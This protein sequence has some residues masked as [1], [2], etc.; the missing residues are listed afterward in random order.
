MTEER[1]RQR[2]QTEKTDRE[3]PRFVTEKAG[4]NRNCLFSYI[5]A[6]THKREDGGKAYLPPKN[7]VNKSHA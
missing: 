5:E 3:K 4:V 1:G 6:R 7:T 2:K